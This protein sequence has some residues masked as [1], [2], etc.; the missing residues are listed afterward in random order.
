MPA[1]PS[2]TADRRPVDFVYSCLGG[3]QPARVEAEGGDRAVR[4]GFEDGIR[5]CHAGG[6]ARQEGSRHLVRIGSD[7]GRCARVPALGVAGDRH[8]QGTAVAVRL[9]APG[10]SIAHLES[11]EVCLYVSLRRGGR[12]APAWRRARRPPSAAATATSAR[13]VP[14]VVRSSRPGAPPRSP[15][16]VATVPPRPRCRG[17]GRWPGPGWR[18][19]RQGSRL[20]D[21]DEPCRHRPRATRAAARAPCP[22]SRS[23]WSPAPSRR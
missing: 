1:P 2:S 18:G 22:R 11:V 21:R 16:P 5:L 3:T 12:Y 8:P 20:R 6:A 13:R 17:P 14:S 10:A 19:G 4:T 23:V 7:E 15:R 9:A